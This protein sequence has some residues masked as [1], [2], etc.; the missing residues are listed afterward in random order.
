MLDLLLSSDNFHLSEEA[1]DVDA[2]H[3]HGL[4]PDSPILQALFAD[5]VIHCGLANPQALFVVLVG[6]STLELDPTI[7]IRR[8]SGDHLHILV[9]VIIATHYSPLDLIQIAA[10]IR[11]VV[12]ADIDGSL[13]KGISNTYIYSIDF[14]Q[15]Q[16]PVAHILIFV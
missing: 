9:F 16:R 6:M 15:L 14:A 2:N 11:A 12:R 4:P 10:G 13:L 1:T 7:I 8:S 5:P 3:L